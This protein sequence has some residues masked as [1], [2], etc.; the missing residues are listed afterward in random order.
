[1]YR[2]MY[3]TILKRNFWNV[4][5]QKSVG[6]IECAYTEG[7]IFKSDYV[8]FRETTS[9]QAKGVRMVLSTMKLPHQDKD[10][11]QSIL[12]RKTPVYV[13]ICQEVLGSPFRGRV[14]A[15]AYANRIMPLPRD[16][17]HIQD[18]HQKV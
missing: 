7:L 15:P 10:S 5:R 18:V 3:K 6:Y 13:E 14:M 11:L 8:M 17:Q 4:S 16:V 1:M 12:T 2:S 9:H